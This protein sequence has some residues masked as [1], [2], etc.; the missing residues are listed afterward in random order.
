MPNDDATQAPL[1]SSL[2]ASAVQQPAAVWEPRAFFKIW[3][4]AMSR[5]MDEYL[6]STVFLESMQRNLQTLTQPWTFGSTSPLPM[7]RATESDPLP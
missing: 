3:L 7:K 1:P 5:S 2:S 4:D 6:R